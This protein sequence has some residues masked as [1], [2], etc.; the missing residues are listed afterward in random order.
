MAEAWQAVVPRGREKSTW[1]EDLS[2]G[3]LYV[4]VDNASTKYLFSHLLGPSLLAAL[5]KR[6][7]TTKVSRITYQVGTRAPEAAQVVLRAT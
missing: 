2:R 3:V 6:L 1:V 4:G 7:R 5:N